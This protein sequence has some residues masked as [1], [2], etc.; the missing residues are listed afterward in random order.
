MGL[1]STTQILSYLARALVM[2]IV[3]PVH[4]AAHAL[5][6]AKLGDTT[7][8]DAGRLTLNPLAHFD[9]IG[10]LCMIVAGFGWAKPVGVNPGRF[11]NPKV[12][13]AIS[14]AAG[15]ISNLLLAFFATI[16]YKLVLYFYPAL[17]A[18]VF[19]DLLYLFTLYMVL[20]NV[21]L[22]VFNLIPLPPLD[23]SRMLLVFLPKRLYFKVMQYER[24]I[25]FALAA[26]LLLG[27]FDRPLAAVNNWVLNL[28]LKLTGF[29]DVLLRAGGGVSV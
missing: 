14:A 15:P 23:G 9:P 25:F 24:Y 20:M 26:L 10:A 2:L 19:T 1:L 13:M 4:E 3:I 5:I 11:K 18:G 17:P 8:R 28:L 29:V 21:S 12:G 22:A 16:V 27:M 6:S 7:A